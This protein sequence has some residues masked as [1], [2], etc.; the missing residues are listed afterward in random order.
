MITENKIFLVA[1]KNFWLKKHAV[2]CVWRELQ[3]KNIFFLMPIAIFWGS[4][5][6][7][8]IPTTSLPRLEVDGKGWAFKKSIKQAL[9]TRLAEQARQALFYGRVGNFQFP[10]LQNINCIVRGIFRNILILS[11][12][13]RIFFERA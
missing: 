4:L 2:R 6:P 11:E 9:R 3:M 12:N 5:D 7:S 8:F 13:H 10:I 1:M